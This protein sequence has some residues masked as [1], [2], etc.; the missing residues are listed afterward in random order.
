MKPNK[1]NNKKHTPNSLLFQLLRL[2]PPAECL[3]LPTLV[4]PHLKSLNSKQ[5]HVN[6][7][8]LNYVLQFA[9]NFINE[10]LQKD[11]L[12]QL[13]PKDIPTYKRERFLNVR[14]SEL[15]KATKICVLNSL[16]ASEIHEQNN[17]ALLLELLN[18][19]KHLAEQATF[20][21]ALLKKIQIQINAMPLSEEKYKL[22]IR[23]QKINS[24]SAFYRKDLYY[25]A[26]FVAH[27]HE[28]YFMELLDHFCF[29]ANRFIQLHHAEYRYTEKKHN[30]IKLLA[31]NHNFDFS[32]LLAL[33]P[34]L[35]QHLD[36]QNALLKAYILGANMFMNWQQEGDAHFTPF[37]DYLLQLHVI[38]PQNTIAPI[39]FRN[40]L[41][42]ARNFC[43]KKMWQEPQLYTKQYIKIFTFNIQYSGIKHISAVSLINMIQLLLRDENAE[44]AQQFLITHAHLVPEELQTNI[45]LLCQVSI[46][47]N[48]AQQTSSIS[49]AQYLAMLNKLL[50]VPID[51]SFNTLNLSQPIAFKKL[52]G[53]ILSTTS[54]RLTTKILYT[55]CMKEQYLDV[56]LVERVLN[57]LAVRLTTWQ[58]KK[59]LRL[60]TVQV[61]RKFI[62]AVKQLINCYNY[63]ELLALFNLVFNTH[64]K[65]IA[66]RSWL[67]NCFAELAVTGDFLSRNEKIYFEWSVRIHQAGDKNIPSL[68]IAAAKRNLHKLSAQ[69]TEARGL[70]TAQKETL[71]NI[72]TTLLE[73]LTAIQ[74]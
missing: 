9:P 72:C 74:N 23:M 43:T 34:Y 46:D 67:L 3:M 69:L 26:T 60:E 2:L 42:Y 19:I 52:G 71:E 53:A 48:L 33:M 12:L 68:N 70:K 54:R 32:P 22:S 50:L 14:L 40:L 56:E 62:N 11:T 36:K 13:L 39:K 59:I 35:M 5:Y 55:M 20:Y 38:A 49:L 8:L 64:H 29:H 27:L 4:S 7:K 31:K 28:Y 37:L 30:I 58:D 17:T 61:N 47:F 41:I 24:N 25:P 51:A 73:E 44:A 21:K 15:I 66:E 16:A 57:N 65:D 1:K 45:V 63:K 6:K 10:A 18:S